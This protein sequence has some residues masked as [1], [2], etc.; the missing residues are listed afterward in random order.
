MHYFLDTEYSTEE[1][2]IVQKNRKWYRR[3]ENGTEEWKMVQKNSK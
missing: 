3:M 2:Q 1:Q